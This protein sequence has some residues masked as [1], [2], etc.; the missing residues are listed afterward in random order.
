[1]KKIYLFLAAI[2]STASYSQVVISQ[3]YGG[4]GNSGATYT[5]D[6]VELLNRGTTTVNIGGWSIQYASKTGVN[7]SKTTLPS[8]NLE[9]GQ[10]FLVQEAT[11]NGGTTPLPSPDF[12]TTADVD[13]I[14][15]AGAEFKILLANTDVLVS[16]V[17][18]PTDVQIVDFLGTGTANYYEGTA[19]AAILSNTTAALRANNGCQ[20]TNDNAA[21]FT[22]AAP[23]PRNS[24]SALNSCATASVGENEIAGLK[25]YPNP[26][27]NG[28]LF[29][30]TANN[31]EKAITVFDV[32]GKQV[33]NTKTSTNAVNVSSLK[34][35]V[36]I[37]KITEEGNTATRKLV[38][39]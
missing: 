38:I 10:Y 25:V 37:V 13:Q 28:T 27:S 17:S 6:F 14:A 30:E 33:L 22:A 34:G 24:T 26:V 2:L 20:D 19:A 3:A 11:G 1:M 8:F 9:P 5:S 35:G 4:G 29:I 36:Y 12:I 32:L 18:N 16:G 31:G 21:D 7:W 39:K 23:A 15:M